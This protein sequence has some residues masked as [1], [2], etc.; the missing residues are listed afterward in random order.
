[1][2]TLYIRDKG[3]NGLP[4]EITF[5]TDKQIKNFIKNISTKDLEKKDYIFLKN[6][7][8]DIFF[9]ETYH[10]DFFTLLPTGIKLNKMPNGRRRE[11]KYDS[12]TQFNNR[13]L[14]RALNKIQE[15]LKEE[16]I[17]LNKG[18]Y[19]NKRTHTMTFYF[20]D[21]GVPSGYAIVRFDKILWE[22]KVEYIE[23][24]E[25]DHFIKLIKEA[26]RLYTTSTRNVRRRIYAN[27]SK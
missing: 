26:F 9:Y 11:K 20:N 19:D 5:K 15:H 21:N 22:H 7:D 6:N 27:H 2:Y 25:P 8:I 13:I 1:M 16:G 24:K 18:K 4:N 14:N 17:R 3:D 10:K 23:S 12:R